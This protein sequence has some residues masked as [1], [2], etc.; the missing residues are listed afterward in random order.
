MR[1]RD[2]GS[3]GDCFNPDFEA[4]GEEGGGA[5]L[6]PLGLRGIRRHLGIGPGGPPFLIVSK[7]VQ[8][9]VEVRPLQ[10]LL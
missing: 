8:Y 2:A 10:E 1:S 4:G 5:S 6:T 3:A 7:I 9:A